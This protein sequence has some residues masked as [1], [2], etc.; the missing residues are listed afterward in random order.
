MTVTPL[1]IFFKRTLT[2][3]VKAAKIGPPKPKRP[4]HLPPNFFHPRSAADQ[5]VM[6]S[7]AYASS[8]SA[9]VGTARQVRQTPGSALP[10]AAR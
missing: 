2:W 5:T 1:N 7:I 10:I 9:L 8:M 3:G 4:Q 6:R